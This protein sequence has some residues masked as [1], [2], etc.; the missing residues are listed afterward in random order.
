MHWTEKRSMPLWQIKY[1]ESNTSLLSVSLPFSVF[2][3][4]LLSNYR[5]NFPAP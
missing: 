2:F 5:V 4:V 1:M 3:S